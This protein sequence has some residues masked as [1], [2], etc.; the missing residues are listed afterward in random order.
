MASDLLPFPAPG[1]DVLVLRDGR[2]VSL[3]AITPAA[4]G[5]IAD[6][7]A[8]MSPETSRRRFFT[9]R[10]QLSAPELDVLTEM[11][12]VDRYAIGA[13]ATRPDNPCPL[14]RRAQPGSVAA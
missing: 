7:V 14:G 1:T 2:R 11:D 5:V 13:S 12:G 8:R 3:H 10:R 6:A 9:V 4:R